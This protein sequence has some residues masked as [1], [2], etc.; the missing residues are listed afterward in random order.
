MSDPEWSRHRAEVFAAQERALA[1]A[2]HA[3]HSKATAL[4][5]DAIARFRAAGIAS[6]PLKARPLRG[7]KPVPTRHV[8]WYLT[9]DRS[10]GVDESGNYFILT[11]PGDLRTRLRGATL[12]P[13]MAP[14]VVGRGGRDGE[15]IDLAELLEKRLAD[16]VPPAH[17]PEGDQ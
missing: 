11:A 7:R 17:K 15:A 9:S 4:I 3:E 2:E 1:N 8:G 12:E 5:I 6:H 10:V 16:P 13:T 14:L